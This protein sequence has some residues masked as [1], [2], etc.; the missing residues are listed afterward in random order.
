MAS[1]PAAGTMSALPMRY[2]ASQCQ[3]VEPTVIVEVEADPVPE[4]RQFRDRPPPTAGSSR[5]TRYWADSLRVG[6][7][8]DWAVR[9]RAE[10]VVVSA[11]RS[12]G[13]C[14]CLLA[15]GIGDGLLAGECGALVEQ[16][17][18]RAVSQRVTGA[19]FAECVRRG[20]VPQL[21]R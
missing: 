2:Q 10:V 9:K 5:E 13:R 4:R 3:P 12:V 6:G 14:S 1:S 7:R 20:E 16:G 8:C 15:Q 18:E 19:L 21:G 11:G 17:G